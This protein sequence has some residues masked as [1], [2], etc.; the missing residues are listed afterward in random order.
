VYQ[1]DIEMWQTTKRNEFSNN[2]FF[3]QLE[4]QNGTISTSTQ[5]L[6]GKTDE[7]VEHKIDEDKYGDI[8]HYDPLYYSLRKSAQ[9]FG[10]GTLETFVY[11]QEIHF[12]VLFDDNGDQQTISVPDVPLYQVDEIRTQKAG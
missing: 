7:S 1:E 6:E 11:S 3:I 5:Y 2:K 9:N 4:H 10:L 12:S 8:P